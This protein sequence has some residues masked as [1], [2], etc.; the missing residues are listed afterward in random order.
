[1]ITRS[2]CPLTSPHFHHPLAGTGAT[3]SVIDFFFARERTLRKPILIGSNSR[4]VD[5]ISI[6]IQDICHQYIA[7]KLLPKVSRLRVFTPDFPYLKGHAYTP[8]V[9]HELMFILSILA[10][11]RFGHRAPRIHMRGKI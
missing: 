5:I 7:C 6:L 4:L 1:M 2:C 9:E 8:S 11:T 3:I 10:E